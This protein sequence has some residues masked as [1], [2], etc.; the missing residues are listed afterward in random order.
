MYILFFSGGRDAAR[1]QRSTFCKRWKPGRAASAEWLFHLD[2][3][4]AEEDKNKAMA[5]AK[6]SRRPS[7][8]KP[9]TRK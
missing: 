5:T 4:K 6:K 3:V 8:G 2:E 7:A 1:R 9:A